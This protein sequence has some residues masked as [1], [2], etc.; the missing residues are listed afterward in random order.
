MHYANLWPLLIQHLRALGFSQDDLAKRAGVDQSTISRMAKGS[1][2][3]RF[4]V[5]QALIELAGG[6]DECA[7]LLAAQALET[8]ATE[9]QRE[10]VNG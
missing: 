9:P 1:A 5:G 2:E 3:Q 7:R 4:S 8:A 10:V 6:Q